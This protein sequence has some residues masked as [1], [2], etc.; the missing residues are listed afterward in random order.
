M[1]IK[2][3]IW[4]SR[5]DYKD[6]KTDLES[7]YPDLSEEE[8]IN[9]MY[10]INN[11]YFNDE[12]I[13]LNLELGRHILV[14]ADLGLWN[15]R[16]SGYKEIGTNLRDCLY[17]NDD[18]MRI[19][20]DNLGDLRADGYHHDGTNHYLYRVYKP[21]VGEEAISNL[22]EKIYCGT[23]TRRDITRITQRLGDYVA[24]IYGF[25]L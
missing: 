21:G 24:K 12:E 22:K 9:R 7:E 18:D 8:R 3:T 19:Y 10:E 5:P 23:V 13:N 14:I 20:I 17:T 4:D 16:H 15:G 11:D 6:W 25:K 1:S 2:Y